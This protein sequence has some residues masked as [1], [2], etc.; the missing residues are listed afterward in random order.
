[1]EDFFRVGVITSTHGIRGEVKIYPTTDDIRRF[2][3]L[4]RCFVDTGKETVPLQVESCKFVRQIPV[5]KFKDLDSIN[6]VEKYKGKDLLVSRADAVPL[7]EH[8]FF[9]ADLIGLAVETDGGLQMGTV[10]DVMKTGANDVFVVE[11]P[12]YGQVLIPYIESC[13][14]EILPEEGRMK[15]HLLDGL[16]DLNRKDIG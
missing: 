1:M 4:D 2:K 13:V 9:I 8:E 3:K 12:Q 7:K 6:E 16:L 10:S 14:L 5:L 11:H 15:V